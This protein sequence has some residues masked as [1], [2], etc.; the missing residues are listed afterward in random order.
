MNRAKIID[1]I[2]HHKRTQFPQLVDMTNSNGDTPLIL[3][4]KAGQFA[5]C[6]TLI[7]RG[8]DPN[9]HDKVLGHCLLSHSYEQFLIPLSYI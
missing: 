7:M 1:G 3:A 4:V 8:A 2:I 6:D 5:A 9:K